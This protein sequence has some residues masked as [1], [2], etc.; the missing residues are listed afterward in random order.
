M[1]AW[2]GMGLG[3]GLLAAT[4]AAPA[5]GFGD[6]V[7]RRFDNRGD[8]IDQR[9]DRRAAHADNLGNEWMAHTWTE[10]VTASTPG[11]IVAPIAP[12]RTGTVAATASTVAGTAGIK[13]AAVCSIG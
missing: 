10:R 7:D 13:P 8:R 1:Q 6:R 2:L 9:L 12:R 11:W 3:L 5:V 4:G